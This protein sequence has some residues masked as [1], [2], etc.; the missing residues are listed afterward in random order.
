LHRPPG[1]MPVIHVPLMMTYPNRFKEA[2]RIEDVVQLLDVMPTILE[3]AEVDRSDLL[4]QGD[5]LVGLIEGKDAERWRDRVVISDEPPEMLRQNPCSCGSIIH[6]DEHLINS[7]MFW[8][9]KGQRFAPN[10]AAF[11]KTRVYAF[12]DDPQEESAL[13]SF[14]PDLY[15]RWLALDLFLDLRAANLA[16]QRKLTEGEGGDL[17]LD[18]DTLED[19]KGLGYVN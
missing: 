13:L 8:P 12:R 17:Q 15:A 1:R 5:S 19:L 14:A 2:R 18:P 3:L 4:L 11:V 9:A 6:R 7:A 16:T 10:L